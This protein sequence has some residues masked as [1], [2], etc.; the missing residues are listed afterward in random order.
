MINYIKRH[1][2]RNFLILFSFDI[3][4]INLS[5]LL[6]AYIRYETISFTTISNL[7]SLKLLLFINLIKITCFKFCYLY[8][9]MWRYT[10]IWDVINIIKANIISTVIIVLFIYLTIGYNTISRSMFVIDLLLCSAFIG[11]SRV[12]IRI[13]LGNI[14]NLVS[15]EIVYS[16][17]KRIVLVGAGFAGQEVARQ[18]LNKH[19]KKYN[20]IGFVDDNPRKYKLQVHG[21][22]VIG[23]TNDLSKS[24]ANK[25]DEIFIC[26]PSATEKEMRKIIEHCKSSGKPFKTLPS[27]SEIVLG[28]VSINQM[29]EV[30]IFDILGRDEISLDKKSIKK[31][32]S[33]KRVLITGG[34]GS[35]GSE[36]VRQCLKFNPSILLILDISE[37]NLFEIDREINNC[38][39]EVL[40]KPLLYDIRDSQNIE[41]VFSEFKPQIVFH[42]A[43]YKHVPMQENFPMEAIKTNILGTFN[44][45]D[46]SAKYKVEKFVLVSTDKAVR[47]TNV[48]GAT[49]RI[50][51]LIVQKKNKVSSKTEF[52]AVRFGNVLG[53][54]GSVIPI[55]QEQ[56]RKG[57]PVTVT[58]PEMERFFMSIP[59][60]SQLILQ[61]CSLGAGGEIFILDMGNPVKIINVAKELIRLSG[62]GLEEIN[63]KIIGQRPG[64]KKIEE[65]AHPD[66]VLDK[67]KHEKIFVLKDVEKHYDDA[68]SFFE[69][70]NTIK[71][72]L[73]LMDSDQ[74]R[75]EL[76][77]FLPEYIPYSKYKDSVDSSKKTELK[78]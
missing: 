61:T 12:G 71:K 17:I 38:D 48:M 6:S 56:I 8:R 41:K 25:Y 28:K 36:L 69:K 15:N 53:S 22:S 76:S 51:E 39:S 33:G 37:L 16:N 73:P 42:A 52:V 26:C 46:L 49:K 20:I 78:N 60:A 77:L 47:P 63:I 10:S 9:G 54:S 64:E 58:D 66:E 27:V 31:F 11:I 50:A 24:L 34:G 57:G 72:K 19:S 59:E 18:V 74:A 35:I 45:A 68:F 30:S 67:T 44:L 55:F 14:L 23:K 75:T 3:V 21:I 7:Y 43:A 29:R 5:L 13:F 4:I 70:L 32:I 62:Y 65:L 1:L 2:N 40:L